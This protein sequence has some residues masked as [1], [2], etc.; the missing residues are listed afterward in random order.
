MVAGCRTSGVLTASALVNSGKCKLVSIHAYNSHAGQPSTITV[1]DNTAASGTAVAKLYLPGQSG[2][3]DD[4]LGNTTT[5]VIG[6]NPI[7]FDMH[8]VMCENGLYCEISGGTV[9]VTVEFA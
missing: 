1:Y 9:A 2:A 7:E 6:N 8:G 4:G 5:E 3:G